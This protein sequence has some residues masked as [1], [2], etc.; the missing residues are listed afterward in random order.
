MRWMDTTVRMREK[1]NV[2]KFLVRKSENDEP[3]GKPTSRRHDNIK[4]EFE[5]TGYGLDLCG[6]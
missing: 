4:I 3:F 1:R 2:L 5:V 6:S